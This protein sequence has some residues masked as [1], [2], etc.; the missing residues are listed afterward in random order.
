[1]DT[2]PLG[3]RRTYMI[4]AVE[5]VSVLLPPSYL[6]RFAGYQIAW[7]NYR[8]DENFRMKD[9]YEERVS[10]C[11]DENMLF[12]S[13][14]T[15][16]RSGRDMFMAVENRSGMSWTELWGCMTGEAVPAR[17]VNACAAFTSPEP[18]IG[19]LMAGTTFDAAIDPSIDVRPEAV[20]ES[21]SCRWVFTF[22]H[23]CW[24]PI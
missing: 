19:D 5:N 1:M 11:E 23:R 7:K 10:D 18:Q 3:T 8:Q 4:L 24:L 22:G 12:L 14:N 16:R 9:G 20:Q 2:G 17:A 15:L 13:K 6:A 21:T